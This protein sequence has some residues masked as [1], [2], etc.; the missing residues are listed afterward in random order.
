MFEFNR[1]FKELN[2]KYRDALCI[3]EEGGTCRIDEWLPISAL[4]SIKEN[5]EEE[6]D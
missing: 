5:G 3:F 6:T 4:Q 1:K 2:Q